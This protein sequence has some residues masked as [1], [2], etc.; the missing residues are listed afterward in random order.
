MP[1]LIAA[2]SLDRSGWKNSQS[3]MPAVDK[4]A[5]ED[6]SKKKTKRGEAS[7]NETDLQNKIYL[8]QQL[9]LKQCK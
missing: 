4:S 5:I 7:V 9:R 6:D 1:G 2:A 8:A 3:S